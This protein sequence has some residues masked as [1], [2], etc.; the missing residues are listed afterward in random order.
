MFNSDGTININRHT[1]F[2]DG[3]QPMKIRKILG[4]WE[5]LAHT[6]NIGDERWQ[7]LP[8]DEKFIEGQIELYGENNDRARSAK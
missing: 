3:Y 7:E 1:L 5:F 4:V 8:F 6:S 2:K